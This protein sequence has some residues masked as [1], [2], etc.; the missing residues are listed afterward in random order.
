MDKLAALRENS[1]LADLSLWTRP[2]HFL[3]DYYHPFLYKLC[4]IASNDSPRFN[5]LHNYSMRTDHST[6]SYGDSLS[7]KG[8]CTLTL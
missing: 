3:R 7:H 1:I 8:L 6:F 5:I 4:R 2:R